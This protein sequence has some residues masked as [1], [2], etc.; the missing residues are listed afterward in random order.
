M[1]TQIMFR[2][3]SKLKKA[4]QMRAKQE[5]IS[6]SDFYQSAT[7]DFVEGRVDLNLTWQK[8]AKSNILRAYSSADS[9]YDSV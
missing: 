3:Q 2:I 9:L 7:R 4:A 8:K 5:G 6:L 1:D